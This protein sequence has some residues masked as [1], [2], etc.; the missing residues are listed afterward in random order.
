MLKISCSNFFKFD[1]SF[2]S[3]Q[4]L[5]DSTGFSYRELLHL[6]DL[7]I[8]IQYLPGVNLFFIDKEKRKYLESWSFLMEVPVEVLLHPPV[9]VRLRKLK[10]KDMTQFKINIL[11][12]FSKF[13][14]TWKQNFIYIKDDRISMTRPIYEI[15]DSVLFSLKECFEDE[16]KRREN[17]ENERIEQFKKEV[18]NAKN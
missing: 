12:F 14:Y 8:L 7:G 11:R 1:K 16:I 2:F 13:K 4:E 3:I 5:V 10:V 17:V 18:E 15:D 9:N 6:K